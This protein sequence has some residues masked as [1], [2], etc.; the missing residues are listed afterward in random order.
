MVNDFF[1]AGWRARS[2]FSW[3]QLLHVPLAIDFLM[4]SASHGNKKPCRPG[5]RTK[6]DLFLLDSTVTSPSS[7]PPHTPLLPFI[8]CSCSFVKMCR[9]KTWLLQTRRRVAHPKQLMSRRVDY[10]L[11]VGRRFLCCGQTVLLRPLFRSDLEELRDWRARA[12]P[13]LGTIPTER[14]RLIIS[15]LTH[16]PLNAIAALRVIGL[17]AIAQPSMLIKLEH[18]TKQKATRAHILGK[19]STGASPRGCRRARV[20]RVPKLLSMSLG[21]ALPSCCSSQFIF[22]HGPVSVGCQRKI[23]RS[24]PPFSRKV[25]FSDTPVDC[26]LP[27]E[28]RISH[29]LCSFSTWLEIW[30]GLLPRGTRCG[31]RGHK[32]PPSDK[33]S[34]NDWLPQLTT[35]T[36]LQNAE[37]CT[38]PK[39]TQ[40][41][42][43]VE[44]TFQVSR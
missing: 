34:Q 41:S 18:R 33:L 4:Y 27:Y 40:P 14:A 42:L 31:Q 6:R 13:H 19:P 39:S 26:Q 3:R 21:V 7:P 30:I 11:L 37:L 28:H 20:W 8:V 12:L 25:D 9:R 10:G 36:S 2:N 23:S 32:L 16:S 38:Q 29:L 1:V 5:Q 22:Q 24:T 15:S 43:I 35:L 44:N 17:V